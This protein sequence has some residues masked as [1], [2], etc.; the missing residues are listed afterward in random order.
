V[1][2]TENSTVIVT[3]TNNFAAPLAN[4]LRVF[5]ALMGNEERTL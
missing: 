1:V 3:L 4:P 5:I 2:F